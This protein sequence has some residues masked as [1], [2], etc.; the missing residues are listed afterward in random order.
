MKNNARHTELKM[1]RGKALLSHGKLRLDRLKIA[2]VPQEAAPPKPDGL[3]VFDGY[4]NLSDTASNK[5]MV[6]LVRGGAD[7]S[8]PRLDKE[9][10]DFVFDEPSSSSNKTDAQENLMYLK[11][12]KQVS[13]KRALENDRQRRRRSSAGQVGPLFAN[14]LATSK[15]SKII[16][17]LR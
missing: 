9:F 15:S 6:E 11:M 3:S 8:R 5:S 4:N 12:V 17:H 1:K 14:H 13:K 7:D 2:G 16:S 10:L